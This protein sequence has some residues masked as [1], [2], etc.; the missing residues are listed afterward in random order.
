MSDRSATTTNHQGNAW[1]IA[2][3]IVLVLAILGPVYGLWK[4]LTDPDS[5]FAMFPRMEEWM[6]RAE[7]ALAA[8]GIIAAV[9]MLLWRKWGVWLTIACATGIVAIEIPAQ[10]PHLHWIRVPVLLALVVLCA[11]KNWRRFR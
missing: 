7:Q 1:L 5:F 11:W 6:L 8:V 4:S 10:W 3:R 9:A 2:L